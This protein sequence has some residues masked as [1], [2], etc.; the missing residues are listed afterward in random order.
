MI[1]A[2][3]RGSSSGPSEVVDRDSHA[4]FVAGEGIEV[5]VV[6]VDVNSEVFFRRE[7]V[8][9]RSLYNFSKF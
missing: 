7:D 4:A 2:S 1:S 5:V 6:E 9:F 3:T 8:S